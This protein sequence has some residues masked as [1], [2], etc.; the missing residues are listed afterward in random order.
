MTTTMT[1]S[2][3]PAITANQLELF[4]INKQIAMCNLL[5]KEPEARLKKLYEQRTVLMAR[6]AAEL[7]TARLTA[8]ED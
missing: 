5:I 7:R 3:R 4:K 1:P 6:V 2:T 8:A